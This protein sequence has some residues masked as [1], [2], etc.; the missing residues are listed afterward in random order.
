MIP[1][2]QIESKGGVARGVRQE[3]WGLVERFPRLRPG[4]TH[5]QAAWEGHLPGYG[6][7]YQARRSWG[8]MIAWSSPEEKHHVDSQSIGDVEQNSE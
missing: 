7:A 3:A 6:P 5:T 1:A 2:D 8:V 4:I